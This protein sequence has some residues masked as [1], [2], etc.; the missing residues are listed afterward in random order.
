M[1]LANEPKLLIADKMATSG[2]PE[3]QF[4]GPCES[5]TTSLADIAHTKLQTRLRPTNVLCRDLHTN[6][7]GIRCL[8]KP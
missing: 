1:A 6:N 3:E 4:P 2:M 7:S 5:F 8:W